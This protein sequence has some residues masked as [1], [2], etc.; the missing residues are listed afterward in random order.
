LRSL[1]SLINGSSVIIINAG[2]RRIP[3][4][5]QT[6]TQTQFPIPSWSWP[7]TCTRCS[8][9]KYAG[10]SCNGDPNRLDGPLQ[11]S[12]NKR[13]KQKIQVNYVFQL[14]TG[15]P[16]ATPLPAPWPPFLPRPLVIG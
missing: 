9:N 14:S 7:S 15:S 6:P 13:Q 11:M 12:G 4:R 16:T 1:P 10:C 3:T 8:A 5:T 2:Q